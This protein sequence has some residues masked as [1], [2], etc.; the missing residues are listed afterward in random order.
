MLR[1]YQLRCVDGTR[2]I[3]YGEKKRS[4]MLQLYMGGGKT[5]FREV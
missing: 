3:L 1:D 5:I 2:D 4:A